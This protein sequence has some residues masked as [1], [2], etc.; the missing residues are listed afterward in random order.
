MLEFLL[1]VKFWYNPN[2]L[3]IFALLVFS[4]FALKDL[5]RPGF[6]TSHDG[7]THVARIAQYYQAL[8]DGQIPPRW[9]KTLNGGFGSPIF[10]YI[11]P[12]PYLFGS[13]I[14]FFGFSFTDSFEILIALTFI[15]SAIFTFL[16]LKEVFKSTN[17][18]FVGALF[19]TWVPYRF[20]LIYVR[21]SISESLA[22]TFVPA[23]LWS[24][25][26]L[27][28]NI[29]LK[30]MSLAGLFTAAVLLS[31]NLVAYMVLPWIIF[32]VLT[33]GILRKSRVFFLAASLAG[34]W[35]LLIASVT[36]I[37]VI[38]ERGLIRFDEKFVLVYKSH[39][40]AVSQLIHSP[41]DYGFSLPS[42]NDGMSFQIGLAHILAMFLALTVIL[43]VFLKN[44]KSLSSIF[45]HLV[46][47]PSKLE[48][49]LST[50]FFLILIVSLFFLLET[51]ATV[52]F[53]K[54]FEPIQFID[55][56]WRFLGIAAL[57]TSFLAAFVTKA[58]KSR[59]LAILL[60]T[61]VII[62]NRNHLR[63][64]QSVYFNDGHF[65]QFEGTAT[66]FNE[67]N[68]KTRRSSVVPDDFVSPI[69]S[70][71]GKIYLTDFYQKSN[72]LTFKSENE[73]PSRIQVNLL[74]FKGWQV[75]IDGQ[76][77]TDDYSLV[78]E[79]FYFTYRPDI[80][81]SGLYDLIVPPGKHNFI[82]K[83]QETPLRASANA[84]SA[85][86]LI[87]ALAIIVKKRHAEV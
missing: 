24:L 49:V 50:F 47:S 42:I 77:F 10:V 58:V 71:K 76:K 84:I 75:F 51:K 60:I 6:Y 81:T 38:F 34:F 69:E 55:L 65:L 14:H 15:F 87:L 12:L 73:K 57:A 56:P 79:S 66:Q 54:Y 46:L 2:I 19:Y 23:L 41:W 1:K 63:I 20:S 21:G 16:W 28:K 59:I 27:S 18:A 31:Q 37:P 7:E 48:S 62:A 4:I 80:D 40:V 39:F 74:K 29:N 64:N 44:N 32:Y 8:S 45:D 11:Y 85:L 30:T 78:D 68:P 83:Y 36:Y 9:A 35:G 17:A 13:V 5:A 25:T 43:L 26:K 67:F 72:V 86:S 70:I 33:L 61:A 52:F 22:Y 3:A 82:F 53:W